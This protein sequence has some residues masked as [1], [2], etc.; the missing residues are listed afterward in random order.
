MNAT[1]I[2]HFWSKVERG[3]G[4]WVWRGWRDRNGYGRFATRRWR[5]LAHRFAW[6]AERGPIT[7]G[8]YVCHHCD[9]RACVRPDHLYLGDQFDNMR[10]MVARG[11]M[12]PCVVANITK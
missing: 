12:N 1:L 8:L 9:N 2:E 10:D 4:C 11:R 6:V 7:G 3:D 5:G